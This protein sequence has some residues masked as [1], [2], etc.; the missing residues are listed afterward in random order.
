MTGE[1]LKRIQDGFLEGAKTILRDRGHISPIGF[2]VTLHKHAEKI[3]ESGW[4]IE[5]IDPKSIVRDAH[6]DAYAVL[7][8][9]LA[10]DYRRMYHAVMKVWPKTRD[11][12]PQM[13]ALGEMIKVD[14]PYK[15]LMRPFLKATNMHEKD[16]IAA[17]LRHV[18]DKVDAFASIMQSEAWLRMIDASKEDAKQVMATADAKGLGQDAKSVEVIFSS[19]E[20]YD[21]ARMITVPIRRRQRPGK[22]HNDSGK[23]LGFGEQMETIDS[24][25]GDGDHVLQGRMTRFLKPLAVAS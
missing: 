18:C 11:V 13:L 20:T 4:G 9:D 7:I 21:F 23:I 16:V 17:T 3:F 24:R 8:I 10:M 5:F 15:R 19:M 25:N 6:D 1:D 14:D 2:V 22:E 12:L